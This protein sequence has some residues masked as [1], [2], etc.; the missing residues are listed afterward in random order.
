[1]NLFAYSFSIFFSVLIFKNLFEQNENAK[2][3]VGA[4]IIGLLMFLILPFRN[5]ML[6]GQVNPVV[7]FFM[8]F[9]VYLGTKKN[10]FIAGLILSIAVMI[11]VTPVL[12]LVFYLAK[13]KYY[14]LFGAIAGI[15][16]IFFL[17]LAAGG[18][19]HWTEFFA[20]LPN[21]GHGVDI[22]G[23]NPADIIAN[24][25]LAGYL[26]RIFGT[27]EMLVRIISLFLLAGVFIWLYFDT[28]KFEFRYSHLLLIP[29]LTAMVITSPLA[30][31]H[32][33]IYIAP[34]AIIILLH[35]MRNISERKIKIFSSVFI[36]LLIFLSIDYPI[37]YERFTN[38][39]IITD[40]LFSF[41][42]F[43]L[44]ALFFLSKYYA[45]KYQE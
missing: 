18:Y 26:S 4:V 44:I 10:Y 42:L 27:G 23:M 39:E 6:L 13:K 7:L 2:F 8:V 9:A 38:N 20:F 1:M 11:K 5:N 25:S 32:H 16:I 15:I 17:T 37:Y 35:A 43:A 30:Y 21:L 33:E 31:L 22:P 40:Y 34:G 45:K 24:F 19:H 3:L 14:M 36:I 41:N 29:F 28:K 12:L